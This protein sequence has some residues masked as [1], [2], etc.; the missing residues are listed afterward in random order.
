[1]NKHHVF[2]GL[3]L[4]VEKNQMTFNQATEAIIKFWDAY[5]NYNNNSNLPTRFHKTP[6]Q[7]VGHG[8]KLGL[9]QIRNYP[10]TTLN[11]IVTALPQ[12][13]LENTNI[14]NIIQSNCRGSDI[15]IWISKNSTI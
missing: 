10:R 11:M 4:L 3:G 1:M 8:H 2:K 12:L 9:V 7:V 6:G 14:L 15:F 13:S 5:M